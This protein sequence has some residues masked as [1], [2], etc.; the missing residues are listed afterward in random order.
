VVAAARGQLLHRG[1]TSKRWPGS[2]QRHRGALALVTDASVDFLSVRLN[3][4]T[5][6]PREN[7][8]RATEPPAPRPPPA[9]FPSVML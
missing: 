6:A 9:P 2:E 8:E 1:E 5:V 7:R 3:N 4:S